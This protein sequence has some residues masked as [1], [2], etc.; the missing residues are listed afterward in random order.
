MRTDASVIDLIISSLTLV[1]CVQSA[2]LLLDSLKKKLPCVLSTLS[3]FIL[4]AL[5]KAAAI[6]KYGH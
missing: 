3:F 6:D 4:F 1:L 2:A 5:I